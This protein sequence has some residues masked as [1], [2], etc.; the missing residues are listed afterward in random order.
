MVP[1]KHAVVHRGT[2]GW[3]TSACVHAPRLCLMAMFPVLHGSRQYRFPEPCYQPAKSK[4][5]NARTSSWIWI[6]RNNGVASLPR[7]LAV[8][9]S[10]PACQPAS[11]SYPRFASQPSAGNLVRYHDQQRQKTCRN[12]AWL[13]KCSDTAGAG[14]VGWCAFPPMRTQPHAC[15]TETPSTHVP[16]SC[17]SYYHSMAHNHLI[18][19]VPYL[20]ELDAHN[21]YSYMPLLVQ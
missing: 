14:M 3:P 19:P 11:Q 6:S 15:E 1:R 2:N 5:F 8:H 10:Y 16:S 17:C 21:C 9:Q 7:T 20:Y 13:V 18:L 4:K 12:L